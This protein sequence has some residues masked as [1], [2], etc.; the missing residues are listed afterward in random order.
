MVHLPSLFLEVLSSILAS[1][2]GA[3]PFSLVFF[4]SLLSINVFS[5]P[6]SQN[7]LIISAKMRDSLSQ[8]E[9]TIQLGFFCFEQGSDLGY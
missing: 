8:T 1:H 9:Y 4:Y 6:R 5:F 7:F 3:S 2:T